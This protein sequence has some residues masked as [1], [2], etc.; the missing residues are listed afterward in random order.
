MVRL[1]EG[2]PPA[3]AER[4][5]TEAARRAATSPIPDDWTGVRLESARDRWLGSL[6]PVLL[7]VTVA[8]SLVL[9]IVCANV[10]VLMLL[11]SMQRQKEVA[12][13]LALGSGWRHIA[14]MLLAET[15]LICSTALGAGIAMTAF[16]LGSL[17]PLIET[18]LGRPAPS[19]A[20]ITIDTTVLAIVGGISLVAAIA[21]SLVPLTSWGRGADECLAAGRACRDRRT[22]DAAPPERTDRIRD[23]RLA[24]VARRLRTHGPQRR[25]DDEHRPRV[26][27]ATA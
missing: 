14:R 24:G 13:R 2:V 1:R 6:R 18:Q 4:R 7:G 9:V 17:S 5:L 16:L 22:A 8:V 27:A 12:V 19:A 10:A 25:A 26:R 3:A 20:G 15:G 23:C 11:R 21:L